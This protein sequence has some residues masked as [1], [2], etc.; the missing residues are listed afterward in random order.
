MITTPALVTRDAAIRLPRVA[1]WVVTAL[2]L[3]PGLFGRDPWRN[4]ELTAY[5]L[6]LAIAEG[7]TA[8]LNPTLAGLDLQA[9][10]PAHWLGAG[11]I[12]L[13]EP[14]GISAPLAARL[15]FAFLLGVNLMLVWYA[16]YRLARTEAAL[17][18]A[19]AFGGEAAPR[20][21][22]R[23]L[24]D[25]AVL[26]FM[27]TLGV[28]QLGHESTPEIIQLTSV[29]LLLWSLATP[30][31]RGW[32]AGVTAM[33]ALLLMS[34]SGAAPVALALGLAALGVCLRSADPALAP[35]RWWIAAGA[36]L[37][38]LVA[39]ALGSWRLQVDFPDEALEVL[40]A[41][42]LL[43]WFTWPTAPLAMITVWR[44]RRQVMR[45]HVAVP[46]LLALLCTAH[47]LL[48]GG[49]DRALLLAVPG[50]AV[51]AAFALPTLSRSASAA[52]DW[53]SVFF[54]SGLA[55]AVWVIYLSLQIG[56][57]PQPARNAAAVAPDYQAVFEPMMLVL[58]LLGTWAWFWLVRWRTARHRQALWKS[59]V[60][61][62]CGVLLNWLLAM[63]LLLHPLDYTRSLTPWIASLQRPIGQANCIAAPGMPVAYAAALEAQGRWVVDA[64]PTAG[65]DSSCEV[66]MLTEARDG[67]VPQMAGWRFQE[68]VRRP[69]ERYFAAH[70]F[71]RESAEPLPP[72][73]AR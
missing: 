49:S 62:A 59:L 60:L 50:I 55:L 39:F 7:R 61:P 35:M 34:A 53:F 28:L 12:L 18:L 4:A 31:H 41:L 54:F 64:R 52:V 43:A 38:A 14:L 19:F 25:G 33:A 26:A 13:L 9:S 8:W 20:D 23:S 56:W 46:A 37:A 1:L 40:Q 42:R 66:L 11:S 63:T 6:M 68:R 15:P 70:I 16:A 32:Q 17:P 27:A 29:S 5:G 51:L 67:S 69:T 58:G 2:Y 57:P 44:W 73:A 48:A 30:A 24:A 65:T 47:A 36:V 71:R 3:L 22:A 10:L 21:Y 72:A 45:R